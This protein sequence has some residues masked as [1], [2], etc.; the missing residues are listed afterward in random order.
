MERSASGWAVV[1]VES[2][3]MGTWRGV[4]SDVSG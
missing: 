4:V 1:V 2:I 3:V